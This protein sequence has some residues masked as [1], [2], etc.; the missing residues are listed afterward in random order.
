MDGYVNTQI[1]EG[2]GIIAFFHPAHN[3]LPMVIIDEIVKA[4]KDLGENHNVKVIL[5]KSEGN[6]TFCSGANFSELIAITNEEEGLTFFS[7]F[8]NIINAIRKCPKLVV[9]RVQGKAVG[10]AVGIASAVDYCFAT[11]ESFIKLSEMNIGIGPFVIGPAVERAI[12]F[13]AFKHMTLNPD[14]FFDAEWAKNKGLFNEVFATIEEMDEAINVFIQKLI[15]KSDG[16]R[17][18]VKKMFWHGTD[19]WDG[20]LHDRA[21]ISGTLVLSDYTKNIL[22]KFARP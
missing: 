13:S 11:G 5:L 19:H 10:G 8:A 16:S 21:V 12:G 1:N 2:L 14:Q 9:G 20:L 7:G 4:F 22:A 6:R 15:S 18:A 17:D 3:A